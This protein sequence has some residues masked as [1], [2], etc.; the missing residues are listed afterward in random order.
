MSR[1]NLSLGLLTF[2]TTIVF[3][4]SPVAKVSGTEGLLL[5]GHAVPTGGVNSWP[6]S[7]GDEI[8]TSAIATTIQFNDGSRVVLAS[9]SKAKLESTGDKLTFR[10]LAGAMRLAPSATS[11]ISFFSANSP[12]KAVANQEVT[13]SA[14]AS[15]PAVTKPVFNNI[16]TPAARPKPVSR[17]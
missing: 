7:A 8:A 10:L 3:A 2:V 11:G 17:K 14:P 1:S 5:R 13:V 12:V 6:V 16:M 4:A 15:T 9:N